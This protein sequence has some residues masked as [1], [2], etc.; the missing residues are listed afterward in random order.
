MSQPRGM[1]IHVSRGSVFGEPEKLSFVFHEHSW[2]KNRPSSYAGTF[3]SLEERTLPM[4]ATEWNSRPA[5]SEA[6]LQTV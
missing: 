5:M 1:P 2:A 6:R 3:A 4:A